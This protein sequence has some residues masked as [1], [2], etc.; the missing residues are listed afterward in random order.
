MEDAETVFDVLGLADVVRVPVDV[1]D[2]LVV[3]V[4][5]FVLKDDPVDVEE[6]ES[7]IVS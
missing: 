5:V 7:V 4:P 6:G 1:L 2:V 3:A